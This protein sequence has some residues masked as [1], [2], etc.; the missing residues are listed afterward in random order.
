MK[1]DEFQAPSF[2][3]RGALMGFVAYII[4][5]LIIAWVFV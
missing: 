3:C 1:K 4:M 5:S 2:T